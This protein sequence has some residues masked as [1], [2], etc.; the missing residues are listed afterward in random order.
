MDIKN[1]KASAKTRPQRIKNPTRGRV[2][3]FQTDLGGMYE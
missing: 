1:L 3:G 2:R